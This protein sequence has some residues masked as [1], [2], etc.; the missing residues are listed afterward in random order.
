MCW[1]RADEKER[2]L[3]ASEEKRDGWVFAEPDMKE[4]TLFT[5]DGIALY[6]LAGNGLVRKRTDI[7]IKKERRERR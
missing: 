1:V 7:E 5:E 2:I 6:A 3:E 4:W